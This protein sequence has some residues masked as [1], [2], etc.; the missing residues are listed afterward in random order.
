[1]RRIVA[2][3]IVVLLAAVALLTFGTYSWVDHNLNRQPWTS[4]MDK[5]SATTWLILGSDER[6]GTTPDS[7]EGSRTDTMLVLIKPKSGPSA[8]ISIPR[9]TLVSIDGSYMKINAVYDVYGRQQLVH[10]VEDITGLRVDHVAM[11]S[12]GG[13]VKVIDALGGVE[14][15]YDQ[16]VNDEKSGMN[17]VA[18]CH[19]TDGIN[20][21]AFS[22]MRYSDPNSDFGRADRQRQVIN[23][24]T[25]KAASTSTLLNPAKVK[26][27]GDAALDSVTVDEDTSPFTLLQMLLAFKSASSPQGISGT[28]YWTDPGYY[29]DGV[30]SSVLLDNARNRELFKQLGD[31]THAAGKVGTLAEQQ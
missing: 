7:N 17:W 27:V 29:V 28:P 30:G 6:D 3:I 9:D 16:D 10:E 4:D 5:G 1:M 26:K 23:A 20:A 15:C 18:G 21:L 11:L 25:K 8:L 22:R 31:G 24:I 19:L 13:L 14:L 2:S 12:F